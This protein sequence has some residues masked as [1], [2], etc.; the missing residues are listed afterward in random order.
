MSTLISGNA[1][2]STSA[3]IV[4]GE[5]DV[6]WE[7]S[8]ISN[9]ND[10]VNPQIL[11]IRFYDKPAD[12]ATV[13]VPSLSYLISHVS[14]ATNDLDTY[15]LKDADVTSQD[16]TF[17]E[18]YPRRAAEV[19][20]TVLDMSNT[21]KIQIMGV[22]PI[23][24]PEVE[25]ELV[26]GNQMVIGD[27]FEK[28]AEGDVCTAWK[29]NTYSVTS[30]DEYDYYYCNTYET[31]A[32]DVTAV[33]GWNEKTIGEKAA[34]VPTPEDFDCKIFNWRLDIGAEPVEGQCYMSNNSWQQWTTFTGAVFSGY[35]LKLTNFE[36]SNFNYLGYQ[37]FKDSTFNDA[38]LSVVVEGNTMLGGEIFAGTNVK[39]VTINT[40]NYGVGMFKNCQGIENYSIG[41]N[42]T[43]IRDDTFYGVNIGPLDFSNYNIKHIGARA[44]ENANVTSVN[45]TGIEQI[46]YRAFKDNDIKELYL[47]KTIK[48][49]GAELFKGN[50]N[51]KKA[52]VAYDTMTSGTA[53]PFHV[54]LDNNWY[55]T[56]GEPTNTIEEINVIAP[57]AANEQVK[58]THITMEQY[59]R[60][61]DDQGNYHAELPVGN[62]DN[63]G[64]KNNC[65]M[66]YVSSNANYWAY[67][68]P[69]CDAMLR[70]EERWAKPD[71]KKNVI[72]PKYFTAI[73]KIKRIIVGDGYEYIGGSAFLGEED[74]WGSAWDAISPLT[75]CKRTDIN[76]SRTSARRIEKIR[77]PESLK[78]IGALA[79]GAA[80]YPGMQVNI[81]QGIEFIGQAAF[82]KMYTLEIDVDFP[83]LKFL[84]DD[85]FSGTLIRNIVL[86]DK[87]EYMGWA[88][89]HNCYGIKDI[90]FDLDLYNP[91]DLIIW[92]QASLDEDMWTQT[93]R[94]YSWGEDCRWS[95]PADNGYASEFRGM[96]GEMY[97]GNIV[98]DA[99]AQAEWG[100][101][102]KENLAY[103]SQKFGKI[104]FTEKAV[105]APRLIHS[106][107]IGNWSY[108]VVDP[109]NPYLP[110]SCSGI[111]FNY[112]AAELFDI[113]ATPWKVLR[114]Y[115]FNH[116]HVDELLLPENLEVIGVFA[117]SQAQIDEP[118]VLPETLKMIGDGAFN[119]GEYSY[120]SYSGNYKPITINHLPQSLEFIGE[121]AF[122][123][124][125][126]VT[127]D[128]N[129]PNLRRL[130]AQAFYGTRVR[131]V[132]L[133]STLEWLAG[134]TFVNIPT[135]RN[136]TID[137]DFGRLVNTYQTR[138]DT[139]QHFPQS[140]VE[141]SED[142]EPYHMVAAET[143]GNQGFTPNTGPGGGYYYPYE[144]F[145]SV[146]GKSVARRNRVYGETEHYSWGDY[147]PYEDLE[148]DQL[149]SGDAYGIITFTDK[150]ITNV[151][152]MKGM[153]AGLTFEKVDMGQAGWTKLTDKD[154]AFYKSKVGTVILPSTLETINYAS[155]ELAEVTNPVAIPASVRTIDTSAF[156][157]AKIG[158]LAIEEGLETINSA[159]FQSSEI[160]G[161]FSLPNSLRTINWAAFQWGKGK[162]TNLLPEGVETVDGG[163]F[164][165]ADWA[166]ELTIPSTL[167][168]LSWGAFNAE[169]ADV[170]YDKVTVK[171]A[172]FT[173]VT[174]QL[175]HQMLWKNKVKELVVESGKLNGANNPDNAY[176][177]EFYNMTIEKVRLDNIPVITRSAFYS[178]D[179]LEEVDMS[180]NANIRNIMRYAFDGDAKLHKIKFSPAVKNATITLGERAFAGTGFV[181]MTDAS[182]DFDLSAA[183]F[184][185]TDSTEVFAEMPSLKKVSIPN[186]FSNNTIPETTFT[187]DP[188][189][190]EAIIGY[191]ITQIGDSAFANDTKL[192][193]VF[194]WGNTV[195]VD[196]DFAGYEE[197]DWFGRGGDDDADADDEAENI[198]SASRTI[199]GQA[200]IYAYS[201]SPAEAYAKL[202]GDENLTGVFYPL[203][204]VLYLTSNKPTVLI[205]DDET[206]FD[207]SNLIVYGLRRDGVVLESDNWAEYDGVA[208]ARSAKP[209]TFEKMADTIAENPDFGTV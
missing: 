74:S 161:E 45:F 71:E 115:I 55:A 65:G 174:S 203:D 167:T 124:D 105:T 76:C 44:F 10:V 149:D 16:G 168:S 9:S 58:A 46:D 104:T 103:Y 169:N 98:Q 207:K 51:M 147:T 164:F 182:S 32:F 150:N 87:L 123:G 67:K 205:N 125:Y 109:D 141:Y 156:Q 128:V 14:G 50:H 97:P 132:Y 176:N 85:A 148:I 91:D 93:C 194:I 134:A 24:D 66:G 33:S 69:M 158:G 5:D 20:T 153:F 137:A 116:S 29:H 2:A 159:A 40:D 47:P 173:A 18:D 101:S 96:F 25:T 120:S 162:I 8:L 23:I 38:N 3:G 88:V 155:F 17:G 151:Q 114:P 19:P 4:T 142:M 165:D 37:A 140:L 108:G 181:T 195:V 197:P 7:Y 188:E 60:Y 100:I 49:L 110:T 127:A 178:C 99:D 26:F 42:V 189:L 21:A 179:D 131:D 62:T 196:D 106:E 166:D 138:P 59:T 198:D 54:V 6:R 143:V 135:L 163:A 146:F 73:H 12:L 201:V 31:R 130:Y 180:R 52:T 11:T 183:N 200:D 53:M 139:Y 64:W 144:T 157:W 199:P 15:F 86:H 187:N 145:Y 30:G 112:M 27:T 61:Y 79:F 68:Y 136:I 191:K 121:H 70:T 22:K 117:F 92:G 208:F 206:D 177:E 13:T 107:T 119:F 185:A 57:Y 175:I 80:W 83:N 186:G 204:E 202:R 39:N 78:G 133:P 77:L 89:F 193:K 113:S 111:P 63:G 48:K 118:L 28:H 90:T 35:K 170:S 81:P 72:A 82:K 190:E 95:T 41:N 43:V 84:G 192:K 34:Y 172:D 209:L 129:L 122:W 160:G 75:Y 171:P 184:D 94:T 1:F 36:A 102:V 56:E 126:N 154:S 152:G